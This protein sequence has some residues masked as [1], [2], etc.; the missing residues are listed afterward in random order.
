MYKKKCT[1]A[2][3]KR[4]KYI[5]YTIHTTIVVGAI[6]YQQQVSTGL[7]YIP[8]VYITEGGGIVGRFYK[9]RSKRGGR[10]WI[11]SFT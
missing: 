2:D 1:K 9:K 4:P 5:I 11:I 3:G 7:K 8:G 10:F 6:Y